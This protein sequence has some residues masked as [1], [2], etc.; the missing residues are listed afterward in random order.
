ML[1]QVH[2]MTGT[3]TLIGVGSI[4]GGISG[5][6]GSIL[7]QYGRSSNRWMSTL[8]LSHPLS[9]WKGIRLQGVGS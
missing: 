4:S 2:G 5:G 9:D 7:S 3:G 8:P 6:V 1:K